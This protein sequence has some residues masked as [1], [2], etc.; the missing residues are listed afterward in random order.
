MS[1]G[2]AGCRAPPP[3]HAVP[4]VESKRSCLAEESADCGLGQRHAVAIGTSAGFIEAHG[5]WKLIKDVQ[6]DHRSSI[7][8]HASE[9]GHEALHHGPRRIG[10]PPGPSASIAQRREGRVDLESISHVTR[11]SWRLTMLGVWRPTR[12]WRWAVE[13]TTRCT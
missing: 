8:C 11:P 12:G 3:L 2:A 9:L 13:V 7:S 6:S 10:E 1:E 4:R 5:I